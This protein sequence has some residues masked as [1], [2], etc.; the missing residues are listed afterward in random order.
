M[1]VWNRK[2][3]QPE[4]RKRIRPHMKTSSILPSFPSSL[5]Q[6]ATNFPNSH[7]GDSCHLGHHRAQYPGHSVQL[8]TK[9]NRSGFL[10]PPLHSHCLGMWA[11]VVLEGTNTGTIS[12]NSWFVFGWRDEKTVV[13]NAQVPAMRWAATVT[14]HPAGCPGRDGQLV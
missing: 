9:V 10:I 2:E 4:Y 7:I 14:F 6:G 11:Q 3:L 1:L 12:W 13:A 8:M 5:F